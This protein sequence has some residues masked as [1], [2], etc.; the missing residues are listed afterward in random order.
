MALVMVLGIAFHLVN[1]DSFFGITKQNPYASPYG[2]AGTAIF[3]FSAL[4]V[5]FALSLQTPTTKR[6]TLAV[7]SFDQS[8]R[9]PNLT[10]SPGIERPGVRNP[11]GPQSSK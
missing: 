8:H 10:N 9:I 2:C 1:A 6:G 4:S 5:A 3:G 11:S 7:P